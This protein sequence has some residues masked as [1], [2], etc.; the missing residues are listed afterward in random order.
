VR[1]SEFWDLVSQVLGTRG[2]ALARDYVLS[3]FQGRSAAEALE[4]GYEPKNVWFALCDAADV[5]EEL[6]WGPPIRKK[7]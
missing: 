5:P 6:R 7:T 4:A 1:H 2:E 3:E